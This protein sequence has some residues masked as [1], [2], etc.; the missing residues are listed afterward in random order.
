MAPSL[1]PPARRTDQVQ[2]ELRIR[3]T[4]L[5]V[6]GSATIDASPQMDGYDKPGQAA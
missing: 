6:T 3:S 4:S 5:G 1:G 2:F